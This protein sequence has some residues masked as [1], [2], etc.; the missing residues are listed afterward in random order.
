[1]EAS[2]L[3]TLVSR[4]RRTPNAT[5]DN[6]SG[7]IGKSVKMILNKKGLPE[8][9]IIQE[10]DC[11]R[12]AA[13]RG[14]AFHLIMQT[15]DPIL[16]HLIKEELL[17]KD[18]RSIY[19]IIYFAGHKHHHIENAKQ[20]LENHKL[21][22]AQITLSISL[23]IEKLQL[24]EEAQESITTEAYKL[25][26]LKT[27]MKANM[28][29]Q[30]EKLYDFAIHNRWSFNHILEYIIELS[31]KVN[32]P[33]IMAAIKINDQFCHQFQTGNCKRENCSFKH[34]MM[35]EQEKKDSNYD[36]EKLLK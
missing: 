23:L 20:N 27:M 4:E 25:G 21:N 5:E 12:Y 24:F 13:E 3:L 32:M 36:P 31:D 17:D 1:M 28:N 29:T 7:Y 18:P 15:I 26:L 22:A 16:H 10:D 19:T 2:D 34:V 6:P 9:M 8:P 30:L 33:I 35:T 14:I 11:Y